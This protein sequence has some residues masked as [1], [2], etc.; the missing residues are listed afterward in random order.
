MRRGEGKHGRTVLVAISQS[1]PICLLVSWILQELSYTLTDTLKRKVPVT[2]QKLDVQN[3]QA[4]HDLVVVSDLH[5]GEG[6][7]SDEP[8]YS[9]TEDFFYDQQFANFL[10]N[11][12]KKYQNEQDLNFQRAVLFGTKGQKSSQLRIDFWLDL[13]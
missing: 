2:L 7:L 4:A 11:L 8:R 9:P 5:L 6:L 13:E 10:G 12:K 1:V 3:D